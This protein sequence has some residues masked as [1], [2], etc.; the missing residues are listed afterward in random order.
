M[1][2]RAERTSRSLRTLSRGLRG[3][4]ASLTAGLGIQQI[5][6]TIS[7]V[8]QGLVAIAKTTNATDAELAQLDSRFRQLASSTATPLTRLLELGSAAGQLGVRGTD[9]IAKFASTIAKLE[10]ATTDVQGAEAALS[11][12]RLLNIA[13]EGV[14]TVD[15]LASVIVRLGNNFA[16]TEGEIVNA[17]TFIGQATAAFGVASSDVAALSAAIAATG[18]RAETAATSIGRSFIEIDRAVKSGGDSLAR[19]AAISGTSVEEFATLFEQDSVGAFQ[20][21]LEGLGELVENGANVADVLES[22]GLRGVE[23]VR[24]IGTLATRAEVLRQTLAEAR[25]EVQRNTALQEE[26]ER[27]TTTLQAAFG[28][29]TNSVTLLFVALG[30]SGLGRAIAQVLDLFA[31]AIRTL[32]GVATDSDRASVAVKALV[33]AL[34]S[35]ATIGAV[36]ATQGIALA[37]AAIGPAVLV[38][39]APFAKLILAV[40]LLTTLFVSIKDQV[41]EFRGVTVSVVEV[42]Q[43]AWLTAIERIAAAWRLFTGVLGFVL[44]ATRAFVTEAFNA[45]NQGLVQP[46]RVAFSLLGITWGG[47]LDTLLE[48]ARSVVNT[49]VGIFVGGF[50]FIV[51]RVERLVDVLEAVADFDP[52]SPLESAGA[53]AS[54]LGEVLDPVSAVQDASKAFSEAF[55]RDFVGEAL[56][57]VESFGD[58]F[59]NFLQIA[60][61]S[62]AVADFDLLFDFDRLLADFDA[63][64]AEFAAARGGG[65]ALPGGAAGA[66]AGAQ[67]AGGASGGGAGGVS[68]PVVPEI[69]EGALNDVLARLDELRRLSG[70]L[71]TAGEGVA[72]PIALANSVIEQNLALLQ[73]ELDLL[74]LVGAE[75]RAALTF[76]QAEQDL[77]QRGSELTDEQLAQALEQLELRR[78]EI[79]LLEQRIALTEQF[80]RIGE[81]SGRVL[82]NALEDA[83]L[84]G[85]EF[86]AVIDRL[87]QRLSEIGFDAFVTQPLSEAVGQLGANLGTFLGQNDAEALGA[88]SEAAQAAQASGALST[89]AS[90]AA[91]ALT[92]AGATTGSTLTT[93]GSTAGASLAA[94]GTQ[95]AS[96]IIAAAS[97]AAATLAASNSGAS[98]L[99]GVVVGAGGA[100]GA[101]TAARGAIFAAGRIQS[102]RRGGFPSIDRGVSAGLASGIISNPTMVPQALLGEGA[103]KE[104]VFPLDRTNRGELAIMANIAGRR[105]M[106]PVGRLAD[107]NLGVQAREEDVRGFR[108]GG[109]FGSGSSLPFGGPPP[110]ARGEPDPIAASRQG[111]S[112][113]VTNVFNIRTPDADS[114]RRSQRQIDRDQARSGRRFT[115]K[116]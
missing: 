56:G 87:G 105:T 92:T 48:A 101:G 32:A 80:G 16:A 109:I 79:E 49:V 89:G 60:L 30:D 43:A 10:T 53:I 55:E 111:G 54:R 12:A 4:L 106:L 1:D 97:Q 74:N 57:A 39:L 17:A 88:A 52:S 96:A 81:D 8:E 25:D 28:R 64:L 51:A 108:T 34:V 22:V 65:G 61:G 59:R 99:G 35:L 107:G 29:L 6:S 83:V 116:G 110:P 58:R 7:N 47:V 50:N 78:E 23:S 82:G 67:I 19:F 41:I 46:V 45:F 113:S 76:L 103:R 68:V 9:N 26:Y 21:F 102:F 3:V 31:G 98:A 14:D 69:D 115:S 63:K 33:V 85:E 18:Q 100:G 38:A 5:V 104:G 62:S 70:D 75:R 36:L 114:F 42:V 40:T 84:R 15:R 93:A 71:E 20:Q 44:T 94:G 73:N 90:A 91:S 11:L 95:A 27:S 24:A 2:R 66:I 77:L 86:D 72:G 112:T 37:I 13:G